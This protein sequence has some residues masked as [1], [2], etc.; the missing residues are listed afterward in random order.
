MILENINKE[1]RYELQLEQWNKATAMINWFKKTENKNIYKIMIF[2]IK[3]FYT[4]ISK[5]LL[6]Y[7]INFARPHV[8][9]KREDFNIIQLARKSLFSNKEIP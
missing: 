1:L 5:N 3:N 9:I 6:D 7:S 4:S 2:D 8:Q